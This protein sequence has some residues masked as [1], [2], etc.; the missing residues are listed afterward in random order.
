MIYINQPSLQFFFFCLFEKQAIILVSFV[1]KS[2]KKKLERN[3]KKGE[4]QSKW[5][6]FGSPI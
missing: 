2:F 4:E 5:D 6:V 1:R 3:K